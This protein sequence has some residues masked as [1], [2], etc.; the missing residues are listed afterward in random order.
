LARAQSANRSPQI[1]HHA[2]GTSHKVQPLFAPLAVQPVPVKPEGEVPSTTPSPQ[3]NNKPGDIFEHALAN[4][5]HFVDIHAH[6]AHFKKKARMHVASM[7]AG[8]LA[9]LFIAGFAAYQNTPGIQFKV[10][11]VQAGVSTHMPNLSAAGFAYNGVKASDGK[12]TVGFSGASGNYQLTQENTNLSGSDVIQSIGATDASGAPDYQAVQ[13]GGT[14]V[15]RFNNTDATWVSG[16]KWYTVTGT[17]SLTDNQ[18]R[19][20]VHNI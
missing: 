20:L 13:A 14:T 11:S 10:A 2:N 5:E 1:S 6:R 16:G 18:V 3:P 9:L 15:Y 8:T 17:G 7:A 4:A 19:D 12:L